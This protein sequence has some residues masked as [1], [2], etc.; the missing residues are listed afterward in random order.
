MLQYRTICLY[1]EHIC[2]DFCGSYKVM[3]MLELLKN[4][5]FSL[6]ENPRKGK[7]RSYSDTEM[8]SCQFNFKVTPSLYNKLT[9]ASKRLGK[10]KSSIA[11]SAISEYLEHI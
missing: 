6:K 4:K 5:V 7:P 3:N 8:R 2:I 11:I 1:I 9:D 10:T